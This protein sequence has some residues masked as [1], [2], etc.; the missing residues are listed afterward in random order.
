MVHALL[1]EI[2]YRIQTL[3]SLIMQLNKQVHPPEFT[4]HDQTSSTLVACNHIATLLSHGVE[5]ARNKLKGAGRRVVAVT[6]KLSLFSEP[7]VAVSLD[8]DGPP[9]EELS[10]TIVTQNPKGHIEFKVHHIKPSGTS[11]RELVAAPYVSYI[12]DPLSFSLMSWGI[13]SFHVNEFGFQDY[14]ANLL[15]G[16]RDLKPDNIHLFM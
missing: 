7:S 8:A 14:A 5:D 2:D 6:R 9:P 13:L 11:L 16:F 10:N 3:S 4:R 15:T 12:H 1:L